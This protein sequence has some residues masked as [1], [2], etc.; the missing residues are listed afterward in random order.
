MPFS[1]TPPT[2]WGE[3]IPE[4]WG[5]ALFGWKLSEDEASGKTL[6]QCGQD[7]IVRSALSTSKNLKRPLFIDFGANTGNSE[8]STELLEKSGWCGLLVEPNPHLFNLLNKNRATPSVCAA[9][10]DAPGI[11]TL[12]TSAE[13]HKLGALESNLGP[14]QMHRLTF[15]SGA[16]LSR[17]ISVPVPVLPL[18]SFLEYF[19]SLYG[20]KPDFIK[21]DI[22]GGEH[23]AIKM[24]SEGKDMPSIIE[25]ENNMRSS[26]NASILHACGY[27]CS[28]VLDSFVEL[29]IHEDS[30]AH[31]NQEAILQ[32]A[33]KSEVLPLEYVSTI[34]V[35]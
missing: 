5:K 6:S 10:G 30:C 16:L 8:S 25:L 9:L 29:W 7:L 1:F 3:A 32:E 27:H 2:Y 28:F 14:Y 26:E 12:R 24:L 22:E 4:H 13:A 19:A 20:S 23:I 34:V 11:Q 31:R 15:E 35:F 18:S 17:I 33:L 21:L